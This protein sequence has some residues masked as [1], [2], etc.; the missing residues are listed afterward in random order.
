MTE[1]KIPATV[2]TGFLGA[3][4]TSTIRHLLA[5]ANGKRLALIIN[6]FGDLGVDGELV[7]G[8]GIEGCAD[9]DVMELANG[10]ICCTVADDFVPTMEQL[11]NRPEPPRITDL[12]P[13]LAMDR[14][15]LTAALK[16]LERRG[17]VT[18]VSD[19]TDRRTRRLVLTDAGIDL[20]RA[21]VP[22]WR[23]THDDID[24]HWPLE[25]RQVL[26][27][28]LRRISEPRRD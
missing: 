24:S 8:C 12:V 27:D 16:P 18:V 21:A 2:I 14:T 3:G 23:S 7:K 10:C 13:F 19:E 9:E 22:V 11:L 6:E 25:D 5:S 4:K 20:L 26:L 17:L 28:E 15:T 1:S